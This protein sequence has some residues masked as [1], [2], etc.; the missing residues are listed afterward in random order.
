MKALLNDQ[1]DASIIEW[2]VYMQRALD[3]ARTVWT[4][5]PNPRVGCVLVNA[6]VIVGEGWHRASGQPHAEVE[7]LKAAGR[8]AGGSIA[9]VSLE[10]CS[11]QG[12]TGP[13]TDALVA[14]DI[15]RAAIA[16]LDPNPEVAGKGVAELEAAGIEVVHLLDFEQQAR[17]MNPGYFKRRE[18][19]LPFVRLKLAMSLDGRTALANGESKWITGAAARADAQRLRAASSAIVTGIGTVLADDPSLNVRPADMRLNKEEIA[20][21]ELILQR[22][23]M[24]IIVDS[25]LQTPGAS[26][27]VNSEGEVRIYAL[28]NVKSNKDLGA[29]VKVRKTRAAGKRVDLRSVIESLAADFSCNEVLVEAGPTLSGAF[30]ECDLVDELIVYMAPKLLGSDARPLLEIEGLRSLAECV[31]FHIRDVTTIDEN[32]RLTFTRK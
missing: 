25:Q 29:N 7:A 6:G 28:E 22:Q 23:P 10:P 24:R 5:T 16:G 9:F 31:E 3:I 32:I 19:G 4:A 18:T 1:L 30:I 12:L 8:Q 13:C 17:A 27:I 14:A 26:R 20:N 2:P 21:N 15:S 11:H